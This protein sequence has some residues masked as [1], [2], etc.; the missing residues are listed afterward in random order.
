MQIPICQP[1]YSSST[2]LI[3]LLYIKPKSDF[4]LKGFDP[5]EGCAALKRSSAVAYCCS[6]GSIYSARCIS[7]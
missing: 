1:F 4:I 3:L 5:T 7:Y 2:A 6:E